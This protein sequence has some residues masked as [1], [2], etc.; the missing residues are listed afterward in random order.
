L[1]EKLYTATPLSSVRV[2]GYRARGSGFDFW[3][4]GIFRKV[5]GLER[6]PLSIMRITEELHGTK[7]RGCG[8][9]S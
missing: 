6:D 2:P 1:Q 7:S 4:Y 5:V 9:E 8:L 3:S